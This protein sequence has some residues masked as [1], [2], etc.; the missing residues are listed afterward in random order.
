M[1]N[2]KV[3]SC[4]V[5]IKQRLTKLETNM[6]NHL[7]HKDKSQQMLQWM[8]GASVAVMAIVLVIK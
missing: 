6:D 2:D 1:D 5:E 7:T 4:F 3:F 8:I